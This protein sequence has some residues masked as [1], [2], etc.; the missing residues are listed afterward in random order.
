MC[1]LSGAIL[2]LKV[3]KFAIFLDTGRE[4]HKA[5]ELTSGPSFPSKPGGPGCPGGPFKQI[6]EN[7]CHY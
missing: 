5:F 4:Q 7:G 6:S 1:S 2:E 3:K